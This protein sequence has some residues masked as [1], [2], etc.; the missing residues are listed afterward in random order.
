MFV[1]WLL[2][3]SLPTAIATFKKRLT[4]CTYRTFILSYCH[5][6]SLSVNLN[7]NEKKKKKNK[8]CTGKLIQE[9]IEC[10][11]I[12]LIF[13][14]N[15]A[16]RQKKFFLAKKL[17]ENLEIKEKL[18]FENGLVNSQFITFL[19]VWE[20][21]YIKNAYIYIYYQCLFSFY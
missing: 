7:S 4:L 9:N 6:F 11:G 14:S 10:K 18:F 15:Q 17:L 20:K 21:S 12:I 1:L 19:W 16:Y 13:L 3:V 2:F 8:N 5:L